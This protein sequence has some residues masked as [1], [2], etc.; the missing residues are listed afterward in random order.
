[1]AERPAAGEVVA[2][3]TIGGGAVKLVPVASLFGG[4]IDVVA[5]M[6]TVVTC[7]ILLG[8]LASGCGSAKRPGVSEGADSRPPGAASVVASEPADLPSRMPAGLTYFSEGESM[9]GLQDGSV[10]ASLVRGL[11]RT[12]TRALTKDWPM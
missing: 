11:Y 12:F 5:R 1:M 2:G 3:A 10:S 6:P 7:L 4:R 9:T 8:C